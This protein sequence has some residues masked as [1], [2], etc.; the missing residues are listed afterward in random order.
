MIV[1]D[2]FE[3]ILTKLEPKLKNWSENP[4][5]C[6]ALAHIINQLNNEII[7]KYLGMLL[8]ILLKL[9]LIPTF[10]LLKFISLQLGLVRL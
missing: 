1:T 6:H 5:A 8:I 4:S 10:L 7:E 9:F 3:E 2:V